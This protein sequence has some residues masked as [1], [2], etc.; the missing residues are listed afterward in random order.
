MSVII[1]W[2]I[3]LRTVSGE[4]IMSFSIAIF[5]FTCPLT[6]VTSVADDLCFAKTLGLTR[7]GPMGANLSNALA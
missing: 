6:R 1:L 3:Q 7:T 2:L 4:K 5:C